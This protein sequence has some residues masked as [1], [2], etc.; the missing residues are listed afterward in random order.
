MNLYPSFGIF[1]YLASNLLNMCQWVHEAPETHIR[2]QGMHNGATT[3][4][5]CFAVSFKVKD[6]VT[7]RPNNSTHRHLPEGTKKVHWKPHMYTNIFS[8]FT[9]NSL[10]LET[11][12]TIHRWKNKLCYIHPIEYYRA[13]K[14]NYW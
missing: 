10:K 2:L 9:Y 6:T 4:E 8:S 13:I 1:K 14:R 5:I 11:I 12:Q 7:I 3:L